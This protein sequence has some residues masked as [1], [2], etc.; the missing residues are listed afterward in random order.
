MAFS[1]QV[2][3]ER[4]NIIELGEYRIFFRYQQDLIYI[5]IT[6]N[7]SSS[8]LIHERLDRIILSLY[9]SVSVEE[10]IEQSIMIEDPDLDEKFEK[11]C[12]LKDDYSEKN[13]ESVKEL[14]EGE[15]LSGEIE[16]GALISLKGEIFYSSLPMDILHT[17]LREIEIRTKVDT[18]EALSNPKFIWQSQEKTTFS[19]TIQIPNLV[20]FVYVVLLFDSR[21]NLGMADWCLENMCKNLSNL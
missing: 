15:I 20:G 4:L 6:Q 17:S 12:N 18:G 19:Q 16:A 8:L 13:L 3:K 14:F 1:V 5:I 9:N 2:I 10:Y 21:V 11:I 7:T